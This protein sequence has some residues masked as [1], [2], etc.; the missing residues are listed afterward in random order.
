MD[1]TTES[2]HYKCERNVYRDKKELII[3]GKQIKMWLKVKHCNNMV[4][5]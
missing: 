1:V 2:T 3:L 4:W 5:Y